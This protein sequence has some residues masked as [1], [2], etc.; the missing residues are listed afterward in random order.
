MVTILERPR[1]QLAE[2]LS[3][4]LPD[5]IQTL[6]ASRGVTESNALAKGLEHLLPFDTMKDV[7]K[8]AIRLAD[9][10]VAQ[11]RLLIIGD[12]DSDGATSTAL[13]VSALR[14]FGALYVDYLVPN[15]FE[16][17]YG[18]TPEIVSV[19]KA[20]QP[21]VIITVDNGI[22]SVEGAHACH[23]AGI[24][25]IITDH[26]LPGNALPKACAIVN[27]NQL[28]CAFPSKHL[29]GVGVI[30]YV[31]L[32]LRHELRLR[33]WF[34]TKNMA[35]PNLGQ[36]LDLV[37]L[38]TVA[39]VVP[40]DNNNRR[41][42]HQGIMRMRTGQL[43]PGLQA[44][45][46]I[47]NRSLKQLVASDL[48]FA[49]APR[50]NAAG[51]LDDMS[52]G[53][54][55]LLADNLDTAMKLAA[56]LDILNT[57][58][59]AIEATMQAQAFKALNDM[60]LSEP[61]TQAAALCVYDA[62]WHQ[63]VIGILASRI[64]DKWHRPVIAFAS[65]G[66]DELK[67][68]ARSI[69]S[70]HIRDVLAAI[71]S[72]HPGLI[73]RF[74][75]HAQA[76]G[77]SLRKQDLPAFREAFEQAVAKCVQPDD[78]NPVLY[79]DG[80]LDSAQLTLDVAELLRDLEPWGQAFPAPLFDGT[81]NVYDQRLVGGKHLKLCLSLPDSPVLINAIAFNINTA[82]WPNHRCQQLYAAYRLDVNEFRGRKDLQL[83]IEH[84]RPI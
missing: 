75:G 56:K 33:D 21:Q 24:D 41:L 34:T 82:E 66:E 19:A 84:C 54:N 51:R 73:T 45:L 40:L 36:W 39:D 46:Q 6:Y 14:A 20:K 27:P 57:E 7:S 53:I 74:G 68:S 38:G 8:A 49:V 9:A 23:D 64:K 32:A 48:G 12:F 31:M 13:A 52:L 17:G 4:D 15:R 76:A 80:A 18:L 59:R 83:I 16:Y 25:L 30:F 62:S 43:R 26:H 55:C 78:L 44:L 42:V 71:A 22:A 47:A 35:V 72:H 50:L 28:G 81:F 1:Q 3:T 2:P 77:L 29:A 67:G 60:S 11:E 79:S 5:W 70:V 65:V 37:A 58:R 63:G 10:L 69:A 61:A